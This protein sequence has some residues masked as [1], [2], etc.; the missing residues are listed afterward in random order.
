MSL[1]ARRCA[2]SEYVPD[3]WRRIRE[4]W[5]RSGERLDDNAVHNAAQAHEAAERAKHA[6]N[7]LPPEGRSNADWTYISP[8]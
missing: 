2:T 4:A 1:A 8:P 7:A 3:L 5:Q 6:E